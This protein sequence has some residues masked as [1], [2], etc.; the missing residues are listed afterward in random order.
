MIWGTLL[1][2]I[3]PNKRCM[4]CG[5]FYKESE[6]CLECIEW[7]KKNQKKLYCSYCGRIIKKSA[8]GENVLNTSGFNNNANL[9]YEC[10]HQKWPFSVAKA[11]GPY[12]EILRNAIHTLK[13]RGKKDLAIP[14]GDL[15][16]CRVMDDPL[17]CRADII[18]P[19]PMTKLKQYKRGFNQ[20]A[21]LAKQV[22]NVLGIPMEEVLSKKVETV[23]QTELNK[24]QRKQNLKD[25][26]SL[27]NSI[28]I[29]NKTVILIDDVMTTGHTVSMAADQLSRG[30]A[31][32]ILVLVLA[33]GETK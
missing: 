15:M 13:Y 29:E 26:F 5:K 4:L 7:L 2:L 9:C 3:F 8:S 19:V 18:V 31:N 12:S 25:A 14:L 22:S 17:Y 1:D 28:S 23:S 11:V 6:I 10:R 20:A 21:L 24:H 30:G 33:V 27:K 16:A 32:K